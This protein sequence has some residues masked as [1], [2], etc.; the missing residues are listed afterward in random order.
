MAVKVSPSVSSENSSLLRRIQAYAFGYKNAV[1]EETHFE[2]L[3]TESKTLSDSLEINVRKL[4]DACSRL[5]FM[6][7]EVSS[8]VRRR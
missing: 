8:L 3:S 4:E 5:E 6:M 1:S 2:P 7:D